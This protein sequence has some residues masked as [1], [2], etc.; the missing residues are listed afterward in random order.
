MSP[1]VSNVRVGRLT[2]AGQQ[3]VWRALWTYSTSILGDGDPPDY[4]GSAT[5]VSVCGKSC[6][7]TASH[8]WKR[9]ARDQVVGFGT[10]AERSPLWL[11]TVTL[12]PEVVT[13][14][15][16]AEWGPDIAVVSFHAHDANR[17]LLEK[18]FY[19]IERPRA[20]PDDARASIVWAMTGASGEFSEI[21]LDEARLRNHT[22]IVTKPTAVVHDG[23]DYLDMPYG[24]TPP[25]NIP[26]SWGGLS[27]AGLWLCHLVPGSNETELDVLPILCGVAFYQRVE[28]Q[29][30]GAIRCHGPGGLRSL[31]WNA[32]T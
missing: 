13:E 4:R 30:R 1:E 8:V 23:I 21:T 5:F 7:L 27:G 22:L 25:Q 17:L 26:D 14:P 24:D 15:L 29:K 12:R 19:S 6:F 10:E 16:V 31:A 20:V 3:R 11:R 32:V 2:E 28:S 18:A 9:M